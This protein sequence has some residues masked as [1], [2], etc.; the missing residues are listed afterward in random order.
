MIRPRASTSEHSAPSYPAVPAP[1]LSAPGGAVA[2]RPLPGNAGQPRP[3]SRP[4]ARTGRSAHVPGQYGAVWD[5]PAVPGGAQLHRMRLG[6]AVRPVAGHHLQAGK[7]ELLGVDRGPSPAAAPRARPL[8]DRA[9][10][11]PPQVGRL[12]RPHMVIKPPVL[13][14]SVVPCHCGGR[15]ICRSLNVSDGPG[16]ATVN[17]APTPPKP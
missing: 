16:A 5:R 10:R 7:V 14:P 9:N 15:G 17:Y 6:L 2:R 4:S 12:G 11:R 1:P 13:F 8:P 3:A